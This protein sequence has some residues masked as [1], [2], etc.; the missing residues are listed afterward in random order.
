MILIL[1]VRSDAH[2]CNRA[3]LNATG[4]STELTVNECDAD[5]LA[6]IVREIGNNRCRYEFGND[7]WRFLKSTNSWK[8]ETD[9]CRVEFIELYCL[10]ENCSVLPCPRGSI[11]Q[12]TLE[13]QE[14][15]CRWKNRDCV[16]G[17]LGF[18]S[19][20]CDRKDHL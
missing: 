19:Y 18:D 1:S 2:Y 10:F 20:C 3:Y 4:Y 16:F 8:L 17:R 11:L 13:E 15:T 9:P 12:G 14:T 7:N 6:R 5:V